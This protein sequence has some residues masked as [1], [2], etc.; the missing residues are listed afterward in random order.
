MKVFL[1]D[2]H[3]L[4]RNSLA[5]HLR[6]EWPHAE[7]YDAKNG[8]ELI[9]LINKEENPSLVICDYVMPNMN[10]VSGV[11]SVL[12][13]L[14]GV[15]LVMISG[16]AGAVDIVEL[17]QLGV[18]GFL[19]KTMTPKS[20]LNALN[21]ILS[22][23]VYV[24]S[25]V[26]DVIDIHELRSL[27]GFG[28]EQDQKGSGRRFFESLT[29]RERQILTFLTDG[30]TNRDIAKKLNLQEITVKVHLKH[31]FRKLGVTNRTQASSMAF[32]M[33]FIKT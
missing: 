28:R 13:R 17:M 8:D 15:P 10:G 1:A 27:H 14:N 16:L 12:E 18:S 23:D 2:D 32:R 30:L 21:L 22:G 9:S 11:K 6:I 7:I 31:V 4:V 5:N 19:M 33:G 20:L 3:D 29:E 24:P 26:L 25:I